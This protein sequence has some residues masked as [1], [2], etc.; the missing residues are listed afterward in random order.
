MRYINNQ[1]YY[2]NFVNVEQLERL[3]VAA[4]NTSTQ[5]AIPCFE[6]NFK[7]SFFFIFGK[8]WFDDD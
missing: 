5:I 6:F 1:L 7:K 2:K 4:F 3:V 8:Q